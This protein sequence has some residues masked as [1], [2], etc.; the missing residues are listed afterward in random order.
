M[1]FSALTVLLAVL[2]KMPAYQNRLEV[3]IGDVLDSW[4]LPWS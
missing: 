1:G 2:G 4:H 3:L